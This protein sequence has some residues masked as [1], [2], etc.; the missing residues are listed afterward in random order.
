M[1]SLRL[2]SYNTRCLVAALCYVVALPSA[3]ASTP[4]P[5][6]TDNPH[7]VK[8]YHGACNEA[9][10]AW[11]PGFGDAAEAWR[12]GHATTIQQRDGFVYENEK[13]ASPRFLGFQGPDD[14]TF[15]VYGNA[16]PPKGH[17]VY[18]ALHRVA[19]YQQ[20]CCSWNEVVAASNTSHPPLLVVARDLSG[21]HTVRGI[22]LGMRPAEVTRIY[23]ASSLLTVP[24]RAGVTMLAYTTWKPLAS[25]QSVGEAFGGTCG[26]FENLYFRADRLILIQLGN[27]C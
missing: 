11:L 23:G 5:V 27:G 21:L 13:P 4:H 22:H 2:R 7:C 1:S 25:G 16:G 19:F 14:G 18:D 9:L 6:P 26:Q 12:H 20:G 24:G 10:G 17:V 3:A 8:L 15:F